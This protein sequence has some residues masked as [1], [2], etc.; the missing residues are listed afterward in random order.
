[1][2]AAC[3]GC[4]DGQHDGHGQVRV[5]AQRQGGGI[6]GSGLG[7]ERRHGDGGPA[8]DGADGQVDAAGE[9]DKGDTDGGN[10]QEGVILKEVDE[11]IDGK[12][13][14]VARPRQQVQRH[15]HDDRAKPGALGEDLHKAF[16]G[17]SFVV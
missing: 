4:G 2:P 10:A 17:R 11:T 9:D 15:A 12:E 1:M 13:P 5:Q 8:D 14:R 3:E 7:D 6:R 16:H